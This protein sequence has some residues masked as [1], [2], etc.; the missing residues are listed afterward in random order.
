MTDRAVNSVSGRLSEA[1]GRLTDYAQNGGGLLSAVT[2]KDGLASPVKSALKAGVGGAAG[3][4]KDSVKD[5]AGSLTAAVTGK[6]GKGGGQKLKVTNIVE[7]IEVGV[8]IDVAYEQW[9]QF[10][11]FPKFMKKVEQVEQVSDEKLRWKAQVFLSHRTWESTIV[12]Q[13]PNDRIV[14]RSKGDKGYVD[15]AVTF[16]ELAPDLTRIIVVLEYH[17]Q[18]FFEKTG[19]LWRAPGRRIRLELKH[20]QR[21]VMTD[22]ILHPDEL[23]GWRGEIRDGEVV[24]PDQSDNEEPKSKPEARRRKAA[25]RSGSGESKP[26]RSR[27]A[28]AGRGRAATS[29]SGA[30]RSE[31]GQR[32]TSPR[33]AARS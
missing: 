31:T 6:G 20:F 23:E 25:D 7:Q 16:H 9:T 17:P 21:H 5:A 8:P 19:N 14:W 27:T 4:V 18:G 22:T 30:A 1:S 10:A 3:K 26:D 33:K 15:G 32:R 29:R 13:V 28:Q 2:G 12:E 24:S 11:D